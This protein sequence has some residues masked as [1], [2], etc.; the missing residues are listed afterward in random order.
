MARVRVTTLAVLEGGVQFS[1]CPAVAD[2]KVTARLKKSPYN[3]HTA[4]RTPIPQTR[5]TSHNLTTPGVM[6]FL[7]LKNVPYSANDYEKKRDFSTDSSSNS[8]MLANRRHVE[9]EIF[10]L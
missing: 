5:A 2:L 6:P 1:P 10:L 7:T 4:P 8:S 3:S 9:N